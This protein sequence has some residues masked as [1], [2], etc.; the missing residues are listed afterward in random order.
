MRT[1]LTLAVAQPVCVPYDVAA[2]AEQHCRAIEEAS[3]DVVVFPELSVT[4]YHFDAQPL[5]PD[6][7]RLQP[8]IST[9]AATETLALIGAPVADDAGRHYIAF[10]AVDGA[11]ARIAYRKMNLGSE[12][13]EYFRSRLDP[14]RA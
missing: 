12:E 5:R 7:G 1:E 4:G 8:I 2:N 14:I 9:C 6:D 11:G 3:A 10:M 13:A